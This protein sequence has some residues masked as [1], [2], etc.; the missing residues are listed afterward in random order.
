MA[1]RHG[2][3]RWKNGPRGRSRPT[4]LGWRI[5]GGTAERH[6][7]CAPTTTAPRVEPRLGRVP[8]HIPSDL[9]FRVGR[10]SSLSRMSSDSSA[11]GP[12]ETCCAWQ[13]AAASYT[14]RGDDERSLP[15]RHGFG[16]RGDIPRQR[17]D[18]RCRKVI[19]LVAR[20]EALFLTH[21]HHELAGVR[22]YDWTPTF[23]VRLRHGSSY[24]RLDPMVVPASLPC[25]DHMLRMFPPEALPDP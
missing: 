22:G 9:P 6:S 12:T 23:R 1:R 2:C 5:C 14:K 18:R 7:G 8:E 11:A 17:N 24:R 21:C 15:A 13:T 25:R 16:R 20:E 10:S 3:W 4:G 19:A